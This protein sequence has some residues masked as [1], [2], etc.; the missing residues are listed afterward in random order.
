MTDQRYQIDLLITLKDGWKE[1]LEQTSRDG[2][3]SMWQGP[4]S[5][6]RQS[7]L[8]LKSTATGTAI[9]RGRND[10]N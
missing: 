8:T 6:G 9:T 1:A 10:T 3:S 7:P 2:Y 4:Q 5:I